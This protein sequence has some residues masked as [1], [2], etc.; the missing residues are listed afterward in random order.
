MKDPIQE[1]KERYIQKYQKDGIEFVF[2]TGTQNKLIKTSKTYSLSH[3]STRK[4][5]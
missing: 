1:I 4:N 3:P 2:S 5:Y